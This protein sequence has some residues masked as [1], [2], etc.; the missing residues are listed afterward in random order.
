MLLVDPAFL[1]LLARGE[2]GERTGS[3]IIRDDRTRRNPSVVANADRSIE[4]IVDTG[5]DV[6]PDRGLCLGQP[7][8]V[9]EIRGHAARSDVRPVAD[10]GIAD[11]GQM[12]D[13]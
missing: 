11:V 6:L 7:G 8:F 12:W 4:D 1:R 2:P 5:P 3:D 9:L 10:L 13:F